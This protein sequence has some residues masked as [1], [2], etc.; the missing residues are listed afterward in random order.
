MN[1]LNALRTVWWNA[2]EA[3]THDRPGFEYA[4]RRCRSYGAIIDAIRCRRPE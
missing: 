1:R 4:I 3:S 2:A